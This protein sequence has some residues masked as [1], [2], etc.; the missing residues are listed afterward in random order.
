M[1]SFPNLGSNPNLTNVLKSRAG[2]G[3]FLGIVTA[4]LGLLL[5]AYPLFTGTVTTIIIG[6]ILI[7]AGIMD[8][9]QAMRAHTTGRFVFRLLLGI[10]YG[11]GGVLLVFH[12]LWG[13][14]VLTMVLGVM[15]LV[16]AIPTAALAI[17]MRPRSG[18]LVLQF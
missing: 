4:G 13:V 8:I 5:M 18:W 3:I 2:W 14:A 6:C 15:L 9:A 1:S 12:P 16:D 10:V 11:F 17:E 7:I